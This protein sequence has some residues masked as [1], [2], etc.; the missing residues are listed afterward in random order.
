[1]HVAGKVKQPGDVRSPPGSRVLRPSSGWGPLPNA[2]LDNV[3]LA[4]KLADADQIYIAPK[5]QVPPPVHSVVRG[6]AAV[7]PV[8]R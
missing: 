6:T 1:V 5:S 3:N 2:D 4:A 8:L 7:T